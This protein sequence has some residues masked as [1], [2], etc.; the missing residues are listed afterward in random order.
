MSEKEFANMNHQH[1]QDRAA[2]G[3]SLQPHSSSVDA[4]TPRSDPDSP[5][6][7][8]LRMKPRATTSKMVGINVHG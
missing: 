8:F 6:S 2:Q 7:A 5:R 1:E 4:F 3:L